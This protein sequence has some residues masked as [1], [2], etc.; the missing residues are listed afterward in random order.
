MVEHVLLLALGRMHTSSSI[1]EESRRNEYVATESCR[2]VAFDK[3]I[4][5]DAVYQLASGI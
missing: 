3:R 1:G 4:F 2:A 5:V